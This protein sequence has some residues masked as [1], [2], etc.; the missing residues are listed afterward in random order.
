[1]GY[2]TGTGQE[3]DDPTSDVYTVCVRRWVSVTPL[4]LDMTSRIDLAVL[5][6]FLRL[7]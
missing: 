4:S 2:R 7:T 6:H 5:D 1:V 3:K